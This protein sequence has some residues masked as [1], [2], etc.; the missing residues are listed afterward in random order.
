MS[1]THAQLDLPP[2]ENV[3]GETADAAAARKLCRRD[4]PS[5]RAFTFSTVVKSLSRADRSIPVLYCYI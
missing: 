3:D 5:S 1:G 4:M 2:I